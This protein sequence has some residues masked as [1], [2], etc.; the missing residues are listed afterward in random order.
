MKVHCKNS[1]TEGK[2]GDKGRGG[3]EIHREADLPSLVKAT[4]H[5]QIVSSTEKHRIAS[6]EVRKLFRSAS[7][8]GGFELFYGV[9]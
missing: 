8:L 7:L 5:S 9:L 1:L 3:K 6:N 4:A 2:A